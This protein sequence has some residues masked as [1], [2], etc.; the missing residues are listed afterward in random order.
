[1]RMT[2][3]L[4]VN[5]I[6]AVNFLQSIMHCGVVS[7]SFAFTVITL[8][9]RLYCNHHRISPLRDIQPFPNPIF[10]DMITK[11]PTLTLFYAG[12]AMST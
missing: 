11:L 8:E 2:P 1:M 9:F 10:F 12:S 6:A 5:A 7:M 3:V 4:S